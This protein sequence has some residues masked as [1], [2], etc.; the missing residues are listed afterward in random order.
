MID[1]LE[2]VLV[3]ANPINV[4][5]DVVEY[6]SNAYDDCF[7]AEVVDEPLIDNDANEDDVDV[8]VDVV[9]GVNPVGSVVDAVKVV[10]VQAG[11]DDNSNDDDD[12]AEGRALMHAKEKA[13]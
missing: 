10:V 1:V 3:V 12:D 13:S 2:D 11:D 4:A 7:I 5:V 6:D 9:C 8:V